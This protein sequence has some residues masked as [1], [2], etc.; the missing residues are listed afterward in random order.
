[1]EQQNTVPVAAPQR[2]GLLTALCILT[3]IFSGFMCL[4]SLIGIFASAWI[5]SLISDALHTTGGLIVNYMV[6][7]MIISLLFWF[8][9]LFGA[10]KM[11]GLKK[12]GFILYV[13]PNG[14]LF[15]FQLIGIFA[16][17]T[18]GGF[19]FFLVSALFIILYGMN[20]KNMK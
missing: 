18:V 2:P 19:I 8:V 13:I 15:L 16:A 11:F 10:I 1:M 3:F 12:V 6:V 17:F 20:L 4:M 9:S 5:G 14:I 7:F